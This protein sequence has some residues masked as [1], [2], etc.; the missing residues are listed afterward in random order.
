MKRMAKRWISLKM[1]E[2]KD[3]DIDTIIGLYLK[4]SHC[5]E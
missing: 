5:N 4:S 2:L 3:K 1:P